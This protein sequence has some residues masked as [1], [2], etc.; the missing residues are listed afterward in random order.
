MRNRAA[1]FIGVLFVAGALVGVPAC[2]NNSSVRSTSG[3]ESATAEGGSNAAADLA[4]FCDAINAPADLPE[5][6]IGSPEFLAGVAHLAA[7][8]PSAI[9]PQF[10]AYQAF[11]AAGGIDPA[12]TDSK[13]TTN[14]P[15]EIQDA[16]AQ[17]K[18][19]GAA[20]C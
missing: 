3:T 14:F 4:E 9:H 8:A 7:I 1:C 10:A 17:I 6:D 15:I 12:N 18:T 19:Y 11:L 5:S 2:G 13:Q 16:I 20:N